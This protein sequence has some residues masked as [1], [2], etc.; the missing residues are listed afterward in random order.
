[1]ATQKRR[2]K[3]DMAGKALTL[4]VALRDSDPE[5]WRRV[6]VPAEMTLAALSGALEEA[7]GWDGRHLHMFSAQ[8]TTYW[9]PPPPECGDSSDIPF[10]DDS[11]YRVGEVLHQQHM[12]L[13]WDYDLG[14]HWEHDIVVESIDPIEGAAEL[15]LC[16]AGGGACP[17]DES[18]G[19]EMYAQ[20]LK[21]FADESHSLH[22]R[23]V[24]G[25]GEDF[26]PAHFDVEG[27]ASERSRLREMEQVLR[28]DELS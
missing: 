21:V 27:V 28:E 17:P 7:M 9:T 4:R 13:G 1:M 6:Q 11:L 23:A 8:G 14:D 16:T 5:V 19:I 2:H 25:F 10:E 3:P 15:T 12:R 18:G 26:D 22:D 24:E 20:L